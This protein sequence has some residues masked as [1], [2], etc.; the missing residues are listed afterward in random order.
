MIKKLSVIQQDVLVRAKDEIKTMLSN[1]LN[2][3]DT[4][5]KQT[6]IA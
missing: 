5:L 2:Q 3:I 4:T 1:M 6:N